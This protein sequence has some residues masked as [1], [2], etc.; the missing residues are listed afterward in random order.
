MN[1]DDYH[2]GTGIISLGK[3]GSFEASAFEG[4]VE[5]NANITYNS[6]DKIYSNDNSFIGK[7]KGLQLISGSY[8]FDVNKTINNNGNIDVVM[9]MKDFSDIIEN[10]TFAEY[11]NDNYDYKK[12]N[13]IFNSLKSASNKNSFN[14]TLNK[15]FGYNIIPNLAKQ[16]FDLERNI[17]REINNEILDIENQEERMLVKI[18]SY[19]QKIDSN[20]N[21][22]GY[23]DEVIFA[24]GLKDKKVSEKIR[25][26]YG[27]TVARSETDFDSE[28]SRYN[29]FIELFTPIN[30]NK[31]SVFAMIKPKVG[32]A[33]GQ[34]SRIANSGIYKA[35]I[36]EMFYGFDSLVKYKYDLD[37]VDIEPML[38]FNLT[39][40]YQDSIKENNN[41]LKISSQNIISAQSVVGL[42]VK[43]EINIDSKQSVLLTAGAK[44]IHEFGNKYRTKATISDM[45]GKYD[46]VDKRLER[47]YGLL[48]IKA[49][50][51]YN[52]LSFNLSIFAPLE[53]KSNEY[54]MLGIGYKF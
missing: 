15:E 17:N 47:N 27:L 51:N 2:D 13:N 46:I 34:Y 21:Q 54:Y 25:V 40:L 35:D 31:G 1:F 8:M 12:G 23:D 48:D 6:F 3:K 9:T 41:G 36:E 37:F 52:N 49:Q 30:Y 44:Y 22:D 38:G 28:S 33:K 32:Y 7:D 5:A 4:V 11:L 53:N 14:N 24:Y 26:G 42:D 39:G 16:S 29:N 45:I 50:Y 19:K 20:S 10:K 43:K 18:S